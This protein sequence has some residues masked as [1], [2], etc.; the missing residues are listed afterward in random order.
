MSS[1]IIVIFINRSLYTAIKGV[2]PHIGYYFS[3]WIF[4]W[5]IYHSYLYIGNWVPYT[6]TSK[7]KHILYI[8]ITTCCCIWH[9]QLRCILRYDNVLLA[10]N[11]RRENET[12]A[13]LNP[14]LEI[15]KV[16]H[17]R[18]FGEVKMVCAFGKRCTDCPWKEEWQ[19]SIINLN[20]GNEVNSG[21]AQGQFVQ[22]N[23]IVYQ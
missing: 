14:S 4:I 2:L 23:I 20:F 21:I 15:Y 16:N 10:F 3:C 6:L 8:D 22:N 7:R 5:F 9:F 17:S 1:D 13:L 12:I 19:H 11:K 18:R